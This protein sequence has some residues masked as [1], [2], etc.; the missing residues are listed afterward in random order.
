[1]V[2]FAVMYRA[3]SVLN[4]RIRCFHVLNVE[5]ADY[6]KEFSQ[7]QAKYRQVDIITS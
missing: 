4:E 1:M 7:I 6:A 2:E 3:L 5:S